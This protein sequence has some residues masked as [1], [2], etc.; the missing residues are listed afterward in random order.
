M[1]TRR[2]VPENRCYELIALMKL[3]T[4]LIFNAVRCV[5]LLFWEDVFLI[6]INWSEYETAIFPHRV[7]YQGTNRPS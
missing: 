5:K 7:I 4:E 6:T 2:Y 3:R 1:H